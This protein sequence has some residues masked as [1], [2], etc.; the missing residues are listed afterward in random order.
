VSSAVD[1][2]LE[3]ALALSASLAQ[4][5]KKVEEGFLNEIGG[6]EPGPSKIPDVMPEVILPEAVDWPIGYDKKPLGKSSLV[7]TT[8][9]VGTVSYSLSHSVLNWWVCQLQSKATDTT[10]PLVF[11]T[12]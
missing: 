12:K 4:A 2:Q 11:F 3:M 8:L 9:Q 6:S 1:P 10:N 7:K 5:Q